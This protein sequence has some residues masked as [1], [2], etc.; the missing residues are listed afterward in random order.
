MAGS[1]QSED[2]SGWWQSRRLRYNVGLVIAGIVAFV[3]YASVVFILPAKDGLEI[4]LFTTALQAI[5][6]MAM[7]GIANLFYFLG[8]WSE[9]A[10]QPRNP[11]R[12]RQTCYRLGFWFSVLLPFSLPTLVTLSLMLSR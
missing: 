10:I 7:V 4:T 1:G 12:Y 6:Y 2:S 9:R 11:E 8:P 3:I 5:G